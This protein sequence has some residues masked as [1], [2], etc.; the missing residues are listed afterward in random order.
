MID[1]DHFKRVNDTHGHAA[2]ICVLVE[3]AATC[4]RGTRGGDLKARLGGEEFCLLLPETA[5]T[6]RAR[7]ATGS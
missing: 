6:P 5:A 1:I 7:A 2:G 3:V 4:N